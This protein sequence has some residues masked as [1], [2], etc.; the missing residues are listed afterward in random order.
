MG[1]KAK[2]IADRLWSRVEKTESCWLWRGYVRP[3]GYGTISAGAPEPGVRG[4]PRLVH[5]VAYALTE[6]AIPEGLTLDHLCGVRNCVNPEHLEPVT[7]RENLLRG[8]TF[9]AKNAAKTHCPQ[10]HPYD[11]ENTYLTGRGR[12]C[13][14]CRRA[15]AQRYEAKRIRRR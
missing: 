7:M 8:D 15:A 10:G 6:G 4:R 9:Q 14:I 1:P 12:A 13:R 11:E 2:P 3:D 5:R